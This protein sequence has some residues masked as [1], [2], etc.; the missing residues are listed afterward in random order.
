MRKK[1][2]RRLFLFLLLLLTWLDL[3]R[4][5][6]APVSKIGRALPIFPQIQI[7]LLRAKDQALVDDAVKE[8]A[9]ILLQYLVPQDYQ[10][11]WESRFLFVDLF[12][13][14]E[15]EVVFSLALPP[16]KGLLVLLQKEGQNYLLV[17]Y[18]A[19]LL[20]ISKLETLSLANTPQLFVT[21]EDHQERFGAFCETSVITVWRWQ[22]N[23]LKEVFSENIYWE[24]NW[25]NTWQN[26]DATPPKWLKLKQVSQ[27]T[28][29]EKKR[30]EEGQ[31]KKITQIQLLIEGEQEFSEASSPTPAPHTTALP[32]EY[33]FNTVQT[34]KI[35]QT[36]YWD[37][38]WQSFILRT[39]FYQPPNKKSTEKIAVLKDFDTHLETFAAN[40]ATDPNNTG[41]LVIDQ[42]GNTFTIA[43]KELLD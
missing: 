28:C 19:D 17:S 36:Y 35:S 15:P 10:E 4:F 22:N 18:R 32:A 8:T 41:Y 5:T 14:S 27:V 37:E 12:G 38:E 11:P 23:Q 33:Q 3:N 6:V 34:R 29:Q 20:P 9:K 26:P 1:M 24:I 42:Q 43:K 25:L 30:Q 31:P 16:E 40:T 21:R 7:D 39:G 2:F 13:D